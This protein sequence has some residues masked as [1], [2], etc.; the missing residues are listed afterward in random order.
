MNWKGG[1]F[2]VGAVDQDIEAPI[3]YFIYLFFLNRGILK[4]VVCLQMKSKSKSCIGKD[5]AP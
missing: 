3:F 5:G 1:I 2:F 4:E